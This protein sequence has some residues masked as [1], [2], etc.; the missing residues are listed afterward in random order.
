MRHTRVS[1]IYFNDRAYVLIG[2]AKD[3]QLQNDVND[4]ML[5]TALSFHPL[6]K[7]E[8]IL[9]KPLTIQLQRATTSTTYRKLALE[10]RLPGY[11]E[12]QLR[13]LNHQYP[14]G[15]PAPGKMVKIV[16]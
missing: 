9:A 14:K 16:R 4:N 6:S 1:I 7:K 12:S 15:E 11:A 10:S 2:I 13:L 8:A 5:K 3:M